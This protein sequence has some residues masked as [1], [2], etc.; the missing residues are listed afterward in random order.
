VDETEKTEMAET[1]E[2]AEK[3]ET[4]GTEELK[5]DTA[6]TSQNDPLLQ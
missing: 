6:I 5:S 3:G 4:I 2:T 1:A